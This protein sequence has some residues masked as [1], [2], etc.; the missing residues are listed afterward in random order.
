MNYIFINCID[1]LNGYI[2]VF[3]ADEESREFVRKTFGYE[4]DQNNIA[5]IN[6]IIPRKDMTAIMRK[7]Y[8]PKIG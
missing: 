6:R 3:A 1:I 2:I 5:K 4:F 7:R 8:N